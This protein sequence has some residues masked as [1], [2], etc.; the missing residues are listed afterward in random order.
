MGK[1]LRRLVVREL[2]DSAQAHVKKAQKATQD[3]RVLSAKHDWHMMQFAE[4][5]NLA[6]YIERGVG[7]FAEA[8][9]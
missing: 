4:L 3:I 2:R 1:K 6:D 5:D 8:E 9:E 7:P